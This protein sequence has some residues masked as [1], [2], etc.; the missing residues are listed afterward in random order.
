MTARAGTCVWGG[1]DLSSLTRAW[2]RPELPNE[3]PRRGAAA[4]REGELASPECAVQRGSKTRVEVREPAA[5]RSAGVRASL[6]D[7]SAR[8]ASGAL[9]LAAECARAPEPTHLLKAGK[10]FLTEGPRN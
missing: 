8:Q 1:E 5:A 2:R 9:R 3:T 6:S 4:H 7:A 10:A